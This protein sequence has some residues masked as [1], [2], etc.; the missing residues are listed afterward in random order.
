MRVYFYASASRGIFLKLPLE[1]TEP[2]DD[3]MSEREE[4]EGLGDE[5]LQ[6]GTRSGPAACREAAHRVRALRF[7]GQG[8][9]ARPERHARLRSR[10]VSR[11]R[12]GW[13]GRGSRGVAEPQVGER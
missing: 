12:G 4:F 1:D 10:C 9:L 5:H 2:G 13:S 6:N 11:A 7:H 8:D 3:T